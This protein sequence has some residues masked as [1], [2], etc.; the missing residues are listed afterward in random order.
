MMNIGEYIEAF[1]AQYQDPQMMSA[2]FDERFQAATDMV[3][4]E[5]YNDKVKRAVRNAKLRFPK[6]DVH[7]IYYD[8]KRPVKRELIQELSTCR[9]VEENQSVILQGYTSSGKTYL[10]CA[11]AKEACRHTYRTRYIRLPNL[12]EEYAQKSLMPGGHEKVLTK[13][14]NFKVLVIDEWLINDLSK[15][16]LMFLFELSERRFDCTATI[17]C[18]LYRHSEWVARL[19]GGTHAESIAERYRYNT[20]KVETG[21]IN[22]R[23]IFSRVPAGAQA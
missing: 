23:E 14:T 17:F 11:L 1:E 10:G 15:D 5:K 4:Q 20:I 13:Y 2:S 21:D 18:T 6:A 8:P 9:Y 3:Y 22:M 16:E 12:L 19:G 7:D